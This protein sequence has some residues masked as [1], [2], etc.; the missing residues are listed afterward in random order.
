MNEKLIKFK[1]QMSG[2]RAA[3]VGLGISNIDAAK[4][5]C[6]IGMNVTAFD[7]KAPSDDVRAEMDSLGV[8]IIQT[9]IFD[10]GDADII[11]RS[12]G[13][14][15][16]KILCGNGK[17]TSEIELF[18]SLC[19]CEIYAVTGSDGKTTTT[20][21][22][23][24]LLKAE[25]DGT[26]RKVWL[27]GNIG[28]PLISSLDKISDSDVAVLEL[29]SFQ[30]M[31]LRFSPRVAV[32]TNI[33]PNHL[34]WHTSMEEYIDSK[35]RIF[36]FQDVGCR[37]VSNADNEITRSL[38]SVGETL[39]FSS[40][41]DAD[42]VI[43]N[44]AIYMGAE[45]IVALSDIV[46]PGT[47]NA[48]NF[49]AAFLAVKDVVRAENMAKVAMTFSGVPHRAELVCENGGVKF[50]NS[51]IDTSPTRTCAALSS[52]KEKV[53]IIIGGYDKHIP[54]EPLITPLMEKTKKIIC[55]G[56]TGEKIYNMMKSAGYGGEIY[57]KRDF[58]SAVKL[59]ASR[60]QSGDIVLLSPA[61]A[62]FDAFKNFEERGE[63]FTN[64]VKN[65]N[66]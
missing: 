42:A 15:P 38:A 54:P 1:E 53:I 16:E 30:L 62:S 46:I 3:L 56:D 14:R 25:F 22:I 31:T 5:L 63:R 29:S 41:G 2:R 4:F 61:A 19:P 23:S 33:T 48:E 47:H 66:I 39:K 10:V 11:L 57:L 65:L 27:G 60:A 12:P 37:F 43:K 34:N 17:M 52:F 13:V 6:G 9:D 44:G 40:R 49:M 21:I 59:A 50:F 24:K 36:S 18:C 45:K 20:T 28:T 7:A 8:R 26:G 35:R 58:D 32:I 55:T 64:I 51:S